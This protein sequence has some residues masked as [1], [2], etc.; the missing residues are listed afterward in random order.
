[1]LNCFNKIGF[2]FLLAEVPAV[3]CSGILYPI[4][5]PKI[6]SMFCSGGFSIKFYDLIP[7]ET[8]CVGVMRTCCGQNGFQFLL[9]KI[10]SV[11]CIGVF[12]GKLNLYCC[13]F[14]APSEPKQPAS[15][16]T[17]QT[18]RYQK[19][20][21]PKVSNGAD[22]KNTSETQLGGGLA[23]LGQNKYIHLLTF[24]HAVGFQRGP[25]FSFVVQSLDPQ[26][27]IGAI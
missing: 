20:R 3:F 13:L 16:A 12:G 11:F 7:V 8:L 25:C 1:M 5:R 10:L 15:K 21:L 14:T 18:Q 24:R 4:I 17:A 27:R 23:K 6:P 2:Q 26:N 22:N 9:T 19:K